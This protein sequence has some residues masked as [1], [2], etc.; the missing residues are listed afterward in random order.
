VTTAYVEPTL[1]DLPDGPGLLTDEHDGQIMR[2]DASAGRMVMIALPR[3][4]QVIMS[5]GPSNPQAPH[6]HDALY[7][8]LAH[9]HEGGGD[10]NHDGVYALAGHTHAA[11]DADTLDG[12][13]STAFALAG[14]D[15]D[16]DYAPL[17]HVHAGEDITS[18]TVADARIASTITRD[19]EVFGIVL[20]A[21]GAGSGLDADLLDGL[22]SAAFALAGHTHSHTALT[23]IGTNTH[24]QID[25]HIADT[26]AHGA[27]GA[28]VGTTNTQTLTN[29]TLTTPTIASFAN[30]GHD[31]TNAAGGGQLG[32]G[33]LTDAAVTNA[34][35]ANMAQATVKGRASGAGTGVPTDLSA[36]QVAAIV[37][38]SITH[39][40]L[41][42]LTTGDPH[43]QYVLL[44]GRSG[45][46]TLNGG[47]AS[48]NGLTLRSTSHATK[49]NVFLVDD[50]G[51]VMIGSSA[52]PATLLEV[53]GDAGGMTLTRTSDTEAAEPF[54]QLRKGATP[55]SIA[56]IRGIHGGGV[57]FT[58]GAA[59]TEWGRF[60][61]TGRL[62]IGTN[63]PDT[64]LHVSGALA[65]MRL[66][67]DNGFAA[68]DIGT[69]GSSTNGGRIGA[70]DS[71]AGLIFQAFGGGTEWARFNA[72][73]HL[74]IGTS[75]PQG[76]LHGHDGTGGFG[77]FIKSAI[78]GTTVAIIPDGSGD[79]AQR[80]QIYGYIRDSSGA[81]A[82]FS[83]TAIANNAS[84][85]Q[86]PSGDGTNILTIRVLA[87]GQ[88]EAQRTGGTRT[89]DLTL[90]CVW[91]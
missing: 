28:V 88:F 64:Q 72:S 35:L 71:A 79:V 8:P 33:A 68:I 13:D 18:G 22:S 78:A 39:N 91:R 12:L 54:I 44:A 53:R 84:T 66:T 9:T 45:G 29:K 40:N 56:Q 48:G 37:E 16:A 57:R 47:T 69:T 38:A 76:L 14:H 25:T 81:F 5:G 42:G 30:A 7:A 15:H 62:G 80:I 75:S 52:T 24:A 31:H 10:H 21:D 63:A 11:G 46:Q 60:T 74:G 85:A 86:N 34:K 41:A 89:F 27:T 49:G 26:A 3:S 19:S 32:T 77:F 20:A 50:G 55:A 73:G 58:D 1:Q 59:T 83:N 82:A 70:V 90:W 43:T 2:W 23:D 36:A 61:S 87:N 4:S 51:S 17:V 67:R 6:N 65:V